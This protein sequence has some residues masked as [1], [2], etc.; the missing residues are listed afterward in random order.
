MNDGMS[1]R[2]FIIGALVFTTAGF[3]S[4]L[5]GC[6]SAPTPHLVKLPVS[7]TTVLAGNDLIASWFYDL[8]PDCTPAALP[9]VKVTQT[10]AHGEVVIRSDGEH[11]TEYPPTNDR[12][13]CNKKKSP[14]VAVIYTADRSYVGPDGF[15]VKAI[16]ED[17][18][19]LEKQI[20]I[21]IK[22]RPA[23]NP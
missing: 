19:V 23:L 9:T 11:Y 4:V 7:E 13:P 8:H 1:G 12:H 2:S 21:T 17:G 14:A 20:A 18:L 5:S 16:F 15:T 3:L 10:A 22:P 6:V